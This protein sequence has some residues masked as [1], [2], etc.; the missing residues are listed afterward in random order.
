MILALFRQRWSAKL[1]TN[2]SFRGLWP[3]NR[4]RATA[5]RRVY[6]G[7]TWTSPRDRSM[8]AYF[9]AS[10][11]TAGGEE[12]KS[13]SNVHRPHECQRFLVSRRNSD[14]SRPVEASEMPC[15]QDRSRYPRAPQ[16]CKQSVDDPA[17]RR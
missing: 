14:I 11:R 13:V 4:T 12:L 8:A 16:C 2:P 7:M 5:T 3:A 17:R 6:W 9:L 15:E 10:A 1:A